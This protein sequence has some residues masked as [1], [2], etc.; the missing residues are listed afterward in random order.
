MAKNK[1][2]PLLFGHGV[3]ALHLLPT[4]MDKANTVTELINVLAKQLL[5]V[6]VYTYIQ[7]LLLKEGD[8]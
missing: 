4:A 5:P 7:I 3:Y 1:V 2:A 6:I 8:Y